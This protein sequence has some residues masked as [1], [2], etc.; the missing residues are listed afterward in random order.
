MGT[1]EQILE[2]TLQAFSEKGLKFTMADIAKN[3]GM[4]KKTIYTVF[5]DKEELFMDMVDYMFDSIKESE[6]KVLN[7]PTLT[8]VE[9]LQRVLVVLPEC[10]EDVDFRQ[11]YPLKKKYP[12]IY[13][14]IER[15]LETGWERTIALLEYGIE[16]GTIRP[17]A[18]PVFK[19]MME[20]TLEKFLQ[21]EALIQD[22]IPYAE[23]LSETLGILM[24]G[25]VN[26]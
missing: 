21:E 18:I 20:A 3:L 10:Y 2:G 12:M 25:I 17:I 6:E 8:T 5:K 23:A 13:E 9:K 24:Y 26:K 7:D 14:A 22:G 11:L 16:E 19:L 15:R 4:S 1:R